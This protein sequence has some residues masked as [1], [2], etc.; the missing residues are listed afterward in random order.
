MDLFQIIDV[1]IIWQ[2]ICPLICRKS[3]GLL[4]S[5]LPANRITKWFEPDLGHLLLVLSSRKQVGRLPTIPIP[6]GFKWMNGSG[7]ISASKFFYIPGGTS[8]RAT[9]WRGPSGTGWWPPE[10]SPTAGLPCRWALAVVANSLG[11]YLRLYDTG[12]LGPMINPEVGRLRDMLEKRLTL[13]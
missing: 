3:A 7:W 9:T 8:T 4:C 11:S 1:S 12:E 5:S 2:L 13:C 10:T 6:T